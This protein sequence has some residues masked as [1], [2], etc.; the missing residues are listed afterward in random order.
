VIIGEDEMKN[1]EV[2]IKDLET[3]VQNKVSYLDLNRYIEDHA[4]AYFT[5][6]YEMKS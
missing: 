2:T 5:K 1:Q 3:G 4:V 6:M